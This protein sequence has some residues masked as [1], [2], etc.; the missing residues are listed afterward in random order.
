MDK[1]EKRKEHIQLR[2]FLDVERPVTKA[3]RNTL[4][5]YITRTTPSYA[6]SEKLAEKMEVGELRS[7]VARKTPAHS[8]NCLTYP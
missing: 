3:G 8:G 5:S 2:A 4:A 6:Q 7:P 1:K